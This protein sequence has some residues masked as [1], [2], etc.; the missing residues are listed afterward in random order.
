M[1]IGFYLGAAHQA[2]GIG[3]RIGPFVNLCLLA[4]VLAAAGMMMSARS[5]GGRA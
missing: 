4:F 3:E 2:L 5:R 1:P